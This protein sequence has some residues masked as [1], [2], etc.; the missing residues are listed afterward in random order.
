MSHTSPTPLIRIPAIPA[1]RV[2]RAG[3]IAVAVL[4]AAALAVVVAVVADS[5]G[6][7]ATPSGG[8]VLAPAR[9]GITP[10][11]S[12]AFSPSAPRVTRVPGRATFTNHPEEGTR[13]PNAAVVT[14]SRADGGPDESSRG[15][16]VF[17]PS[18]TDGGP[19]EGSWKPGH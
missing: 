16:L 19:E 18:R 8:R 10:P 14:P 9:G 13:G 3:L 4:V 17:P 2:A 6:H 5:G 12:G 7:V 1:G 15:P 11:A